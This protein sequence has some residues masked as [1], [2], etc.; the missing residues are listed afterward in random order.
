M[1]GKDVIAQERA[2]FFSDQYKPVADLFG[3]EIPNWYYLD[4]LIPSEKKEQFIINGHVH[5]ISVVNHAFLLR[6]IMPSY[7]NL[8][9]SKDFY[10]FDDRRVGY[11]RFMVG[12]QF[13]ISN[14]E[15]RRIAKGERVVDDGYL[16]KINDYVKRSFV[17]N[18]FKIPMPDVRID[19]LSD[20]DFEKMLCIHTGSA[21]ESAKKLQA[22]RKAQTK[23][24]KEKLLVQVKELLKSYP[25]YLSILRR[26]VSEEISIERAIELTQSTPGIFRKGI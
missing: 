10:S 6:W 8:Y 1:V 13:S 17:F 15:I 7:P 3:E 12:E 4:H 23:D 22:E 25:D 21:Q 5:N 24:Q 26:L 11:Y 20:T 9:S 2:L 16:Q 19:E 18:T 14:E